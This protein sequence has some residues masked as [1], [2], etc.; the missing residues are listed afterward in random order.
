MTSTINLFHFFAQRKQISIQTSACTKKRVTTN[1][2]TVLVTSTL[3]ALLDVKS[4][5]TL[6]YNLSCHVLVI[7]FSTQTM[8]HLTCRKKN[9]ITTEKGI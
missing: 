9:K 7:H 4:V 6:V 3:P 1:I 5:N 8:L 2:L